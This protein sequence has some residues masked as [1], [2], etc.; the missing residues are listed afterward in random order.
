MT[1]EKN[2]YFSIIRDLLNI[3]TFYNNKFYNF[4]FQGL[5]PLDVEA[6]INKKL[7]EFIVCFNAKGRTG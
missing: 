2:K 6:K 5:L 7:D 3:T 4:I 1:T